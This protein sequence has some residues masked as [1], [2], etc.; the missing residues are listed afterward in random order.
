MA[1]A[2]EI[3][4]EQGA[5]QQPAESGQNTSQATP[6]EQ[7]QFSR[8]EVGAMMLVYDKDSNGAIAK[9]LQDG[10]DNAPDTLAGIALSNFLKLDE[11]FGNKI[12]ASMIM[13]VAEVCLDVVIDFADKSGT[14]PTDENMAA[15]ALQILVTK[16]AQKYNIDPAEIQQF[17]QS[18][19]QQQVQ[20]AVQQQQKIAGQ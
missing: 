3:P 11:K 20:S 2:D 4:M 5:Q 19:G 7:E 14:L 10:A 13:R 17:I 1:I 12:P 15:K 18:Q 8:F 16:V 9:S 6:Q